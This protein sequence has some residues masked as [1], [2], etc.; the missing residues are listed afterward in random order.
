MPLKVCDTKVNVVYL[1]GYLDELWLVSV[2]VCDKAF[3]HLEIGDI[4]A[5]IL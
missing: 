2:L 5:E 3:E 4:H 1:G